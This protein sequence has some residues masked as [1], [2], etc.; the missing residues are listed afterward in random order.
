MRAPVRF[1]GAA[2]AFIVDK[3]PGRNPKVAAEHSRG[4]GHHMK[5]EI[6]VERLGIDVLAN[7]GMARD[8]IACWS[9]DD[10]VWRSGVDN[11]AHAHTV[12]GENCALTLWIDQREGVVTVKR[13]QSR[14]VT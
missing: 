2:S 12:H 1:D 14:D 11:V 8:D 10:T 6:V 4:S 7:R 9:E 13:T 3:M 5:V